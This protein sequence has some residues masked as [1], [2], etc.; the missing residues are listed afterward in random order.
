MKSSFSFL[1]FP[2]RTSKSPVGRHIEILESRIAPA[3]L[4]V[5]TLGALNGV[6][7]FTINPAT[8][9][10]VFG[11]SVASAG[12]IN[13]DGIGDVIIGAPGADTGALNAG[14]SYVLFGTT[15][16]FA[17]NLA[18][19]AL[20]GANGF[21]IRGISAN[22]ESGFS[23]SGLG[24]FNGDGV[25][26]LLIGAPRV[27]ANGTDS[28][29]SY[30]VFGRTSGFGAT[31]E[32]SALNGTNGFRITG[33][34][35]GDR[36][37][38]SAT[39]AGDLNGDGLNDLLLGSRFADGTGAVYFIFGSTA[40]FGSAL[41]L[42][43]LNGTNGFKAIGGDDFGVALSTA[44]DVNGDGFDDV[45]IGAPQAN[46]QRGSSYVVFG[47]ASGFASLLAASEITG[48]TGFRIHGVSSGTVSGAA[49]GSAGD[50]NGDG[51]DDLVIGAP[52]TGAKGSMLG[53]AHVVFGKS[54]AFPDVLELSALGGNDGFT[55]I[56]KDHGDNVGVTVSRAGDVNGDGLDD[57]VVGGDRTYVYLGSA[58]VVYGKT[59]GFS[60]VLNVSS[61]NG[62][63][64]F[65]ITGNGAPVHFDGSSVSGA[66]DLNGDG[67]DD[68][69]I[70]TPSVRPGSIPSSVSVVFGRATPIGISIT[71]VSMQEGDSESSDAVFTVSLSQ[72]SSE[73]VSVMYSTV[74]DSA[75]AGD[76]FAGIASG[77]LTFAPGET[78]KTIRVAIFGDKAV[79]SDEQFFVEL[80]SPVN[81][82]LFEF[83]SPV[84]PSV[85][86]LANRGVG[87][88]ANDESFGR[89]VELQG[90]TGTNGFRLNGAGPFDLSGGVVSSAG[91]L[92]GD[93]FDDFLIGPKGQDIRQNDN[94]PIYV[95]FGSSSI[96]DPVVELSA[97]NGLNGFRIES[98]FPF[99]HF[100]AS[101]SDAGD[102]NGDGLDDIIIGV[103]TAQPN[104]VDSGAAYVVFGKTSGFGSVLELSGL[105]GQDGFRING[106]GVN[107]RAG[108]SVSAAGDVNADGVDDIIIEASDTYVVFGK[109]SGFGSTMELSTINGTNG[110]RITG[111]G[112]YDD[113]ASGVGDFNGDGI[114]DIV[115]GS[116]FSNFTTVVFGKSISFGEVLNVSA[117]TGTDGF[118][119]FGQRNEWA[120][121]A[122]NGDDINGDGLDDII[123]G[124]PGYPF[125]AA[126]VY[127]VF[128]TTSAMGSSL[129]L[130]TLNGSD[131]FKITEEF[132]FSYFGSFVD[133]G[134]V[135]GD[136]FA[137]II[138]GGFDGFTA[139]NVIFG[140]A[141]PFSPVSNVRSID[142]QN[143]F[144]MAGTL[145]SL[146]SAGD[147]NGD[148]FDD[149][150]VGLRYA[151]PNGPE[152]GS[153]YIVF[154]RAAAQQ[155]LS[156][157]DS[158]VEEGDF[159][160]VDIRFTV[161]LS[162]A[163]TEPI[164][165]TY[166]TK[167]GTSLPGEDFVH[168]FP[169]VLTFAPGETSKTIQVKVLGDNIRESDERFF[170]ELS[171][172]VNAEILQQFGAGSIINDEA[173]GPV[174]ELFAINGSNGFRINGLPETGLS[175]SIQRSAGDVNG[176]GFDDAV[177]SYTFL[178]QNGDYGS[179]TSV[180]FGKA[181][182]FDGSLELSAL[183]GTNG[184][185][186]RNVS[187]FPTAN[188]VADINGDGMDDI[189][190]GDSLA[191][192]DANGIGVISGA[193]YVVF[194]KS[195]GFSPSI[196]VSALDGTNGFQVKGEE[197]YQFFGG[198]VSTGD[199]NDDG[200]DDILI[201]AQG[202][203]NA[204]GDS[205]GAAY[206]IFGK[207]SGFP[208][209]LEISA[210]N[211][212]SGF[213]IDDNRLDGRFGIVGRAGDINGD[214][215]D[216]MVIGTTA[217]YQNIR[218]MG[219]VLFGKTSPFGSHLAVSDLNGTNG[220]RISG[221]RDADYLGNTVDSGGDINGD[222]FDDIIIGSVGDSSIRQG[223]SYV[224]FGKAS[225]F[226]SALDLSSL[227]G[228]NG[229]SIEGEA[230]GDSLGI[231]TIVGDVNGDGVD[232]FLFGA[233][234]D[235]NGKDSGSTYVIYGRT[236]GFGA[237]FDPATL[238]GEN[239]F[240][241]NGENAGDYATSG[242]AVGDFNGDGINDIL[243]TAEGADANGRNSGASYVI[244]G[245]GPALSINDAT[246]T[247]SDSGDVFAT[248]TVSL[249]YA[250]L[251]PVSVVYESLGGSADASD[252]APIAPTT[253]I[254][255]PGETSKTIS[256]AVTGDLVI[257]GN[258][259]FSIRLSNPTHAFVDVAEGIGTI[260]NDDPTNA[261][262]I[263]SKTPTS[264]TD[265][266]GDIVTISLRGPGTGILTLEG[267]AQNG[268]NALALH[269]TDTS[270]T[271]TVTVTVRKAGAGNGQTAFGEVTVGGGLKSFS[272]RNVDLTAAGF[273]STGAVGSLTIRDLGIGAV[274]IGGQ[275]SDRSILTFGTIASGAVIETAGVL[276][277]FKAVA[278]A[279][280]SV[281]AAA[282]KRIDVRAGDLHADL[283][284][285]GPVGVISVK[286]TASGNWSG[287]SF[288]AIFVNGG[289]LDA[290]ISSAGAIGA[291]TVKNGDLAGE[292]HALRFG[293]I[294]VT[295]GDF[296]GSITSLTSAESLGKALAL[297]SL[298][299]TNGDITGDVR[300]LGVAGAISTVTTLGGSGGHLFGASIAASEIRS[301]NIRGDVV[302]SLVLAGADLGDDFTVGGG[303]DTF[304]P[305]SIGTIKIGGAVT[306]A[307]V[308]AAGLTTGNSVLKDADDAIIGGLASAIRNLTIA[309][310]AAADSYFASGLFRAVKIQG[311]PVVFP[312]AD[313]RFFTGSLPI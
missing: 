242:R 45:I 24:D 4:P 255:A 289:N 219:F 279:G 234:A 239:G 38:R 267:D 263:T 297:S 174:V 223:L 272:A 172:P 67:F 254:F 224:V 273:H 83:A 70:G 156:V 29:A 238:N 2:P 138:V 185:E 294:A 196:S 197:D 158:V 195:S 69:I 114:D 105:S 94:G 231:G 21:S 304:R 98:E 35:A 248:F 113:A 229:F 167:A 100:G 285:A 244:F 168:V 186:I 150:L 205:T 1:S 209:V 211:G 206:V 274:Q 169:T 23:V 95:V 18:I 286:G 123:I 178:S 296:S 75:K 240:R 300:L 74:S 5:L 19:S 102:V 311:Q 55:I 65:Q 271:T 250:S 120:G 96:M 92:N 132:R 121:N 16:A 124:A 241:I 119:I 312:T 56:G 48:A 49:V 131:G 202:A 17:S 107:A 46:G 39:T 77:V 99:K 282:L 117:L 61:L 222:G 227:D 41:S 3:I 268:A 299:V 86:E 137:D 153:G 116:K 283:D 295:W 58:Y 162:Q 12:D 87:R 140:K 179:R 9:N 81:A 11:K 133:T 249:S 313:E 233:F 228:S 8:Q 165:V 60:S 122:V 88:I 243:I 155:L 147:V 258:E 306:G 257:E 302:E 198:S 115:I 62:A 259:T 32:L 111:V 214:G 42:T 34:H 144:V 154:G 104:G 253:L 171:N 37:G 235:A 232:D 288:Q 265:A 26:D 71:N 141:S 208:S 103:A 164:S 91:D 221:G 269:L 25:D 307:S 68:L 200:M 292:I 237:Q 308:I 191:Y 78:V 127:V 192:A 85:F 216:D 260:L 7:G 276:T 287:A 251:N 64:G 136:G 207:S 159:G 193:V 151:D 281:S 110:F 199:L 225:G 230:A 170:V 173:R 290:T 256:V 106:K 266:N 305:G 166:S 204:S 184:F 139:P 101:L 275:A 201:G 89:V 47:K 180:V 14:V 252:F 6:D 30:V 28:G 264:Y 175:N 22:D 13:G 66:G 160:Q 142:G 210:L 218:G 310:A 226:G 270:A 280:A 52:L 278:V 217:T 284:I 277:S 293:A 129:S 163:S 43:G 203:T 10:D 93:G 57:L 125:Y 108:T 135:N 72:A 36:L 80:S 291:V 90:L 51:F 82:E 188:A 245:Q 63:N 309:G 220:F 298:K 118:R 112:R 40:G 109:T 149:V 182:G 27:D 20:N 143:G 59:S 148:G 213:R 262:T 301:V 212:I 145:S 189:I 183:D 152:S 53:A 190:L 146:S 33:E 177:L 215:V 126:S 261:R 157:H 187:R 247:E 181:T 246:I 97:I 79:E 15:N 54:T 236:S 44:G 50:L 130:S 194:G 134:D 303:N 31:V 128:G 73:V 76:D 84:N 161:T 176:D